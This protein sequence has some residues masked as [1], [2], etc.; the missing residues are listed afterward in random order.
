[1]MTRRSLLI[2]LA[3]AFFSCDPDTSKITGEVVKVADG[4]TFTLKTYKNEQIKIRLYGIDAPEKGQDFGS[5]SRQFLKDLC[6]TKEV[7]VHDMGTDQYG[8]T[9]GI[10]FI[11]DLNINEEMVRNGLAWHYDYFADDPRLAALE[12]EARKKK[13]NIWSMKNPVSP[14]E[15][16]KSKRNNKKK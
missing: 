12:K 7:T 16:R 4:D 6:H 14:Y 11:G 10:A 9:L 15:Y 3:V 5:K 8:R 1:M 13:L 2:L